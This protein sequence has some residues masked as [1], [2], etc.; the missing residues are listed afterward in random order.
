MRYEDSVRDLEAFV[1]SQTRLSRKS[2]DKA[3][4]VVERYTEYLFA[5]GESRDTARYALYGLAWSGAWPARGTA[6]PRAMQALKGWDKTEPPPSREPIPVDR[7]ALLVNDLHRRGG[8][9]VEAAAAMVPAFDGYLRPGEAMTL[10][11][12]QLVVP[13]AGSPR[14]ALIIA[15]SASGANDRRREPSKTG[16]SDDAIIMADQAT[17]CNALTCDLSCRRSPPAHASSSPCWRCRRSKA[18]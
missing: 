1:K 8:V 4:E 7:L 9:E 17:Q 16:T 11:R 3:D 6:F 2:T 18:A 5:H 15:P 10:E 12:R 13:Y 14:W